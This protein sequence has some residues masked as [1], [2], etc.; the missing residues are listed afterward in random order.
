MRNAARM[1]RGADAPVGMSMAMGG[2]KPT[3]APAPLH[4]ARRGVV[5]VA[6]M[7]LL[8]VLA[9]LTIVLSHT[10][11]VELQI[12]SN[13]ISRAQADAVELGAENFVLS[14][15]DY[16]NTTNAGDPILI[17]NVDCEARQVGDGYFWI[18]TPN[19]DDP[20]NYYY[21]ITDEAGKINLNTATVA[22]LQQL[23]G[24]SDG[25]NTTIPASIVAW[26]GNGKLPAA[27][28]TPA[29]STNADENYYMSLPVNP[30]HC[31]NCAFESVD[32]LLLVKGM[33][34]D[35]TNGPG[36]VLNWVDPLYGY[37]LHHAGWLSQDD[38]DSSAGNQFDA[39]QGGGLGIA[40]CVTVWS[41]E[42]NTSITGTARV[43]VNGTNTTAL[44]TALATTIGA[45][46][47]TTIINTTTRGRPFQNMVDY[48]VRSGMT[49]T[50]FSGVADLLSATPV[51]GGGGAA[52]GATATTAGLININTA[53]E[54]VL[55][56][57]PGLTDADVQALVTKRESGIDIS[58]V[59]WIIGAISQAK[60][61]AIGSLITTR[62]F[63]YSADIVAVSGDGRSFKRV[64]IVV[65]NQASPPKILYRKD[66]TSLGWPLDPDIQTQLRAGTFVAGGTQNRNTIGGM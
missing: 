1:T 31:K 35:P 44:R 10:V 39:T 27:G 9:A 42:P 66:L 29:L 11:R 30:Y 17:T 24:M 41:A 34:P 52:G 61:V 21:G 54:T 15:V 22:V 40:P 33:T 47:V 8:I 60:A 38:L 48:F 43:N 58:N 3:G 20:L 16:S 37:D 25:D 45:A 19:V 6:V 2:P 12:S 4:A 64:R 63:Q 56:C 46:R 49:A 18:L 13:A 53:S 23:P 14:Q 36:Q 62:S 55:S 28:T 32:E 50:E 51:T 59:S 26:R 7:W 5:L 65:D 57:L